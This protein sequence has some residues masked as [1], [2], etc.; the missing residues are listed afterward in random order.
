[1]FPNSAGSSHPFRAS[2]L[3]DYTPRPYRAHEQD[4]RDP[5]RW[6]PAPCYHPTWP[7]PPQRPTASRARSGSGHSSR[8]R[9]RPGE[10]PGIRAFREPGHPAEPGP[11]ETRFAGN[12]RT[13][14]N[15][16]AAESRGDRAETAWDPHGRPAARITSLSGGNQ[17]KV[18][19]SRWLAIEPHVLVMNEPTCAVDVGA[20]EEIRRL[21]LELA[22]QGCSFVI[23]SSELD[24]LLSLSDRIL[25]MTRG[26]IGAEFARGEASKEDLI[27]LISLGYLKTVT[28]TLG[29]GLELEAIAASVIGGTSMR[30]GVGSILGAFPGAFIMAEVRTG[31]V[32][33]G[34]DAYLQDACV[35][36]IIAGAVIL[37]VR[38]SKRPA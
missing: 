16:P 36:L 3:G 25:V 29:T 14:S 33:M 32:L 5:P 17:Q 28:P 6:G 24:E 4:P 8:D 2:K 30:G 9:L 20:K 22:S 7:D 27:S 37:N 19:I 18:L 21:I 1:M 31:L 11:R 15:K 26:E 34:T 23:A 10:S 35:G 12:S 13:P 38:L